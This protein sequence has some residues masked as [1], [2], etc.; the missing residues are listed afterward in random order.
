[1]QIHT[2][3]DVDQRMYMYLFFVCGWYMFLI[4]IRFLFAFVNVECNY[5]KLPTKETFGLS[6]KLEMKYPFLLQIFH[7]IK[8]PKPESLFDFSFSSQIYENRD[9]NSFLQIVLYVKIRNY[10]SFVK[11][12]VKTA[13]SIW[14]VWF[15]SIIG[16]LISRNSA[17][18]CQI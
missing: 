16:T 5:E 18:K 12:F 1:M 15:D 2:S 14:V 4:W 6:N 7:E 10:L 11:Y 8:K 9:E 17:A 3:R 13:Y